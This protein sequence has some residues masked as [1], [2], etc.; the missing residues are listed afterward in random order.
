MAYTRHDGPRS[1]RGAAVFSLAR[2]GALRAL[3]ARRGWRAKLVPI[4]LV[5]FAMAPALVVLGVRALLSDV[6]DDGPI[7]LTEVLPLADYQALIGVVILLFA[8]TLAPDLLCPDRRDGTLA[9][10]FSTS[11]SRDDYLLGRFLAAVAPLLLVTLAPMLL[12]FAGTAF[13]DDDALGHL[14]D[15][16]ADVPRILAAGLVLAVY[17][18]AVALAVAAFTARKAY[19]AGGYVLLL[20]GAATLSALVQEG[21][22]RTRYVELTDLSSLPIVAARQLFPAAHGEV[23]TP[24]WAW[25]AASA[26][27]VAVCCAVVVRRYRREQV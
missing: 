13:F 6:T 21:L 19:A 9:L 2:W 23:E 10:Y 3:G 4:V 15:E 26:V 11:V 22:D 16:W 12:L 20:V 25:W 1:G 24:G 8:A 27:V 7:D 14:A 17:Y 18:A 5:L